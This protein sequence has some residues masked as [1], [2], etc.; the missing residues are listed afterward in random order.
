MKTVEFLQYTL[1]PGTGNGFH[2][3]MLNISVPLHQAAGIDVVTHGQSEHDPDSYLLV[4]AFGGPEQRVQSLNE[5]YQSDAWRKGPREEIINSI[6]V[7]VMSVMSMESATI[8]AL[9]QT[10]YTPNPDCA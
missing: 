2:Q 1:Q 5:F 3:V 7:S 8:D 6:S 10:L 4:R 9:R